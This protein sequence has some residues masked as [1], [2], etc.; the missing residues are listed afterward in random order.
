VVRSQPDF[1]GPIH[2][3][4]QQLVLV[5]RRLRVR[6]AF[7][8][9][10]VCFAIGY[11]FQTASSV[12]S[13]P[14]PFMAFDFR[15]PASAFDAASDLA[16]GIT[17]SAAT[18]PLPMQPAEELAIR[19]LVAVQRNAEQL[20]EAEQWNHQADQRAQEGD[21]SQALRCLQQAAARFR[22]L[23]ATHAL[24]EAYL[25]QGQ[26]FRSAGNYQL[27]LQ[28]FEQAWELARQTAD[29]P[30]QAEALHRLGK[31]HALLQHPDQGLS[32]QHMALA[33]WRSEGDDVG[34]A[35][36]LN[37]IGQLYITLAQAPQ[38][39][40]SH[41]E[42]LVYALKSGQAQQIAKA[43][44]S[45]GSSYRE[46]Q[47]YGS[48]LQEMLLALDRYLTLGNPRPIART[49]YELARLHYRMGSATEAISH[50]QQAQKQLENLPTPELLGRIFKLYAEIYRSQGKHDQAYDYLDRYTQARDAEHL[51]SQELSLRNAQALHA[52]DSAQKEAQ[53]GSQ[54]QH[55][56]LLSKAIEA[57]QDALMIA[58]A[59]HRILYANPAFCQ[60][61]GYS[62]DAIIGTKTHQLVHQDND[63][64]TLQSLRRGVVSGR[65]EGELYH[66]KADGSRFAVHGTLSVVF[67]E[68]G[69]RLAQIAI[70]RDITDYQNRNLHLTEALEEIRDKATVI[71]EKNQDITHSMNYAR[72]I[73]EAILPSRA[74][75]DRLLP[76]SFIL[77]RPKDIVCGDFYWLG[78]V[79]GITIAATVDCTGH[80]IPAALMSIIGYNL[81]SEIILM[82][83]I[84]EPAK[85]LN[86]LHNGV[87]KALKQDELSETD[88]RDGM[89]VC[90]VAIDPVRSEI[91]YAGAFNPLYILRRGQL[92][93]IRA[94][95][96][97][98]GGIQAEA[99][100]I[101]T[102]HRI[103][104]HGGETIYLTTDGYA[105]QLG[106]PNQKRY[107]TRR[108]KQ[109]LEQQ[110]GQELGVQHQNLC[111]ELDDWQGNQEQMDDILM[112]GIRL[113]RMG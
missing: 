55:I 45:L 17:A 22:E 82:K 92:E 14:T 112:M 40:E 71:E 28:A 66:R 78:E 1:G 61:Y 84:K 2:R 101:F 76:D 106:G 11:S 108:L 86:L 65:W 105:N 56:Q 113:K 35:R 47:E 98:I 38:A 62:H 16:F 9:G 80:G 103:A 64:S 111:Q 18:Q 96:Y 12:Q 69:R 41:K 26:V 48:A 29:V 57:I 72:R 73:Q 6:F 49:L 77:Y 31:T 21:Y 68:A 33:L 93:E 89:D 20:A 30:Q 63:A 43:H 24:Y 19:S 51:A 8:L 39:L 52:Y 70:L 54:T 83:R 23:G 50:L 75:I 100:R 60:L 97:P 4:K 74:E 37:S 5:S 79:D 32:Y 13:I 94:D 7:G 58:D 27:A 10:T 25:R 107:T 85:I 110:W 3:Q 67:D 88:N 46:N 44:Q 34:V 95:K 59:Q 81:L 102:N 109:L 99:L 15:P 104:F 90:L 87:R 36:A 42:A 53:I 91:Q